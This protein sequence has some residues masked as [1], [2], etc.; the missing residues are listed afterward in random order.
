MTAD[1]FTEFK[2][3]QRDSWKSF[4]PL[5]I[6]TTPTA[7][8][9]VRFAR[10]QAG[11]KVLDVGCGTGVV[12]I[13]ARRHGAK[14]TGLDLTPELL[15]RAK[16]HGSVPGYEDITWREGD[17][18]NLP[19]RDGEFDVVLSQF[20]HMFAP[21]PE[22]ATKEMLRV[23]RPGGTIAFNTWPPE[24]G[25]GKMFA[26]VGRHVP[27]PPGVA[28]PSQWGDVAIVRERL[29]TAVKDIAFDRAALLFPALSVGHYRENMEHT[30]GPVIKLVQA[31]QSDPAKLAQFRREVEEN[32]AP[33]YEAERNVVRQD[34][35]TTRATKV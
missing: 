5:E 14:V 6:A 32:F 8:H 1:P 30:A 2:A 12:A 4:A 19:F 33:Y 31:L 21:R 27:P 7:A 16:E 15:A 11:Q 20:G 3:K 18:E 34:Y 29:G 28:P 24:L 17:V 25:I 26:L 9:L 13:T 35:L 10:V 22:V 23:L